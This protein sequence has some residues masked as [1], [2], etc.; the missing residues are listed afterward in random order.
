VRS[1]EARTSDV[2]RDRERIALHEAVAGIGGKRTERGAGAHEAEDALRDHAPG[3]LGRRL[4][5]A[6]LVAAEGGLQR[7]EHRGEQRRRDRERDE[8][9]D[10]REPAPRAAACAARGHGAAP[11]R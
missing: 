10:Q 3:H 1:N 4:L 5:D 8:E 9:F 7:H 11:S 6:R 2:E